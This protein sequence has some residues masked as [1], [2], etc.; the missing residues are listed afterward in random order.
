MNHDSP[1]GSYGFSGNQWVSF[2]DIADIETKSVYVKDNNYGGVAVCTMDMD[3]FQNKCCHGANP[4]LNA[5]N[6]KLR[7]FGSLTQNCDRPS[8]PVTPA[9]GEFTTGSDDG[10][11][12]T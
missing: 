10:S 12:T 2:N 6:V 11:G 7:N 8:D 3:D 1:Y 4:L 9:P 5:V